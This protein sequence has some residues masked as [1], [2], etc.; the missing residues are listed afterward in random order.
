M[1]PGDVVRGTAS[2]T[3][4]S[5]SVGI[6]TIEARSNTIREREEFPMRTQQLYI[7]DRRPWG[8]TGPLSDLIKIGLPISAIDVLIRAT[9]GATMNQGNPLNVD[10]DN[11]EIIDGTDR[12]FS[13][14]LAQGIGNHCY[15][16]GK[17]PHAVLNE[18]AAAVQEEG[19]RINF[20]RYLGDPEYWLDP[21][22]FSNL[23]Y[24][25]AGDLTISATAGCATGTRQ[26][27]LIA[28]VFTDRPP[29]HDGYFVTKEIKQWTTVA[30]GEERTTIPDDKTI[31]ALGIRQYENAIAWDT[32][33]SQ[34]KLTQSKDSFIHFDLRAVDLR[35][36]L[37]DK[38]GHFEISQRIFRTDADAFSAYMQL[39]QT[40]VVNSLLDLD[41]G[42]IDAQAANQLTLQEL[43]LTAVP[44]IAKSATDTDV[45]VVSRGLLPHA[46]IVY[47]MGEWDNPDEWLKGDAVKNLE[48]VATQGGAGG[49]ASVWL[50]Q[51]RA[52]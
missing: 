3:S 33:V 15:Q 50:Q 44:A 46:S 45:W 22:S 10:V 12:I 42:S 28:H 1:P 34:W 9:H 47:P 29:S 21:G 5:P 40:F 35:D 14:S 6:V 38:Y 52:A 30:T 41:L 31:R 2:R 13:L 18:G 4:S 27:S 36:I 37:E 20:G 17:Y 39:P 8:D 7:E 24:R 43:S 23:M 25:M 19:F 26:I 49:A 51:V 48:L 16:R 32:N 11:V